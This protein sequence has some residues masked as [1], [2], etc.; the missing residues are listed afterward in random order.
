MKR[1]I[2]FCF[3]ILL[4]LVF[5]FMGSAEGVFDIGIESAS[6]FAEDI[7]YLKINIYSNPGVASARF[8]LKY[9]KNRLTLVSVTDKGILGTPNFSPKIS[10]DPYIMGWNFGSSATTDFKNKGDAVL[11]EFKVNKSAE[12]G[13]AEVNLSYSYGDVF[14]SKLQNIPV[15]VS[16]GKITVVSKKADCKC[17][18]FE[19]R[20]ALAPTC[21][22]EGIREYRCADCGKVK[23]TE[24]VSKLEYTY[25]SQSVPSSSQAAESGHT[26]TSEKTQAS[27]KSESP[28]SSSD[29]YSAPNE[30]TSSTETKL[31][32]TSNPPLI[33]I[34]IALFIISV[35]IIL[36]IV[37]Y[38][39]K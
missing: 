6:A 16:V 37:S 25:L 15:S 11:L 4:S 30:A 31:K 32:D 38:K 18:V 22:S 17:S 39:K 19:W 10:A 20:T 26:V 21:N 36:A 12:I 8:E 1:I 13:D 3:C 7:V 28:N 35:I 29:V 24:K 14:N 23:A 34:G 33:I 9:D 5:S 27:S 2:S